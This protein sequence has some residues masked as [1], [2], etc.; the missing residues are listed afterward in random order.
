M[1]GYGPVTVNDPWI[2]PPKGYT[3]PRWEIE[4]EDQELLRAQLPGG[5]PA[6]H[7]LSVLDGAIDEPRA[8]EAARAVAAEVWGEGKDHL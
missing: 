3:M 2:K 5:S 8:G 1:N 7:D 4:T 6:R